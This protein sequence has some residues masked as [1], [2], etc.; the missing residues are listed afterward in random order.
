MKY[1]NNHFGKINSLQERFEIIRELTNYN[2]NI[3]FVCRAARD[4]KENVT[5]FYN[6]QTF[7]HMILFKD[8][9]TDTY[10]EAYFM[11]GTKQEVYT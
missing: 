9:Y 11:E 7:Q 10:C 2:Y 1:I 3:K 6:P 5:V 8:S 4:I